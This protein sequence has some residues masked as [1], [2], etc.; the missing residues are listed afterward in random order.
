[1]YLDNAFVCH[2]FAGVE[3]D[4]NE[5]ARA[6]HTNHLTTTTFAVLS[7]FNDTGQIEQLNVAA[8]VT[9]GTGDTRQRCESVSNAPPHHTTTLGQKQA[10]HTR[11]VKQAAGSRR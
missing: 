11:A 3:H 4:H 10:F 7:T 5:V 2:G 9:E 8:L 6:R 1:V